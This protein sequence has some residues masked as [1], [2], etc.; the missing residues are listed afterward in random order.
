MDDTPQEYLDW[1]REAECHVPMEECPC[2]CK[3]GYNCHGWDPYLGKKAP[4]GQ[5]D[6]ET[7]IYFKVNDL[8]GDCQCASGV[9]CKCGTV[10]VFCY[11][12]VP[13]RR[14]VW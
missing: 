5:M 7:F 13:E 2:I 1:L 8:F 14:S 4:W 12:D 11:N 3:T 9:T 10:L 6:E